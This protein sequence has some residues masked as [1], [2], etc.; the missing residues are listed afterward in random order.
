VSVPLESPARVAGALRRSVDVAA[1]LGD[2]RR[3]AV[4][5]R[6]SARERRMETTA[7]ALFGLSATVL[8]L[9]GADDG[10]SL[11][12]AGL[13]VL[14]YALL[15]RVRFELGPGL[16]RPTELVFVPMVFVMPGAWVPV[17]VALG[18]LLGELP[19]IAR[20]RAH[21][22]RLLVVLSDAWYAIGPALVVVVVARVTGEPAAGVGVLA[23]VLAAQF[24]TDL[25]ASSLREW[26]GAGVPPREL[27]R[28]LL[29]VALV[30]AALALVGYLAV[31]A[32]EAHAYA[33]L[34]VIAPGAVLGLLASERSGRIIHELE[35]ERALRRATRALDLRTHELRR[36]NGR[37][38]PDRERMAAAVAVPQDRAAIERVT[39]TTV[40]QAVDA[41]CGRLSVLTDGVWRPRVAIGR[42]GAMAPALDAAERALGTSTGTAM[43]LALGPDYRLAVAREG[44]AFSSVEREL[45]KHLAAQSEL[46]LESLRFSELIRR[47][48]AELRVILDGIADPVIVE[49]ALGQVVYRNPAADALLEDEPDLA[50]TL[51]VASDLLPAHLVFAGDRARPLIVRHADG[52]R[53]SRVKAVAVAG[54]EPAPPLAI[55]VVEDISEIK[56]AEEAQRFLAE[57][58]RVLASSPDLE[59]TVG[60]VERLAAALIGGDWTIDV[61]NGLP[62]SPPPPDARRI[63]IP[64]R[65]GVA[66]AITLSGG[67]L[68]PLEIAVAEDLSLRVGAAVDLARL[69]RGR[70]VISQALQGSLLPPVP[71]EIP[72][73]ETAGLYRPAGAGDRFSTD[74]YDVFETS[75]DTCFVLI[76]AVRGPAAT[77]GL[78]SRL[79]RETIRAAAVEGRSPADALRRLNAVLL[80]R[81]APAFA[82]VACVRLDLAP[83]SASATVACGGHPPPRILRANGVVEVL[84]E[85]GSPL[86]VVG[87]VAVEERTIGLRGGDA[88]VLYTDGLTDAAAPAVW[89]PEDLH[90]VIAGA[91]GRTAQGIV[92]HIAG[93]VE[94]P[95]GDDLALLAVRVTPVP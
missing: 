34:L 83:G 86:G 44:A 47:T 24:A 57:S 6:L 93:I 84:G 55:S 94:G 91:L 90:T 4:A 53:W 60:R 42:A 45:V 27:V 11:A 82:G 77:A 23:F 32:G 85:H 43:A 69:S 37:S 64:V 1:D 16:I 51:G 62:A 81:G 31:L 13:L 40:V 65:G 59:D 5:R 73:L 3:P 15:R 61:H 7:A 21:P 14:A 54:D 30:D 33:Y 35:W 9:T 66:G 49:D 39:V 48:E 28:V 68:G 56:R 72:G 36:R 71:T 46:A 29:L 76:G 88:L 63:P 87:R 22:E 80:G 26:F 8:A 52:R 17:L 25:A 89:T 74:F 79:A 50:S 58:S 18:S 20:R 67:P 2:Q 12:G 75:P 10:G 38:E 92:D 95:L 19:D 41:D 78:V 70:A